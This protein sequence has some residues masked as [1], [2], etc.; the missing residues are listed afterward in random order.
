LIVMKSLLKVLLF[1]VSCVVF[2]GCDRVTKQMAKDHL[3]FSEPISYFHDTFRFEYVENTGAAL[4]VGDA[5]PQKVS[6]WLL[7]IVPLAI[8]IGLF[9]YVI[10]QLNNFSLLKLLSFSLVIAGG[11]GNIIDRIAYDRH[12]TDFMNLGIKDV[13]TGIFN[14]ADVC[15]TV[16]VIGLFIAYFN[17]NKGLMEPDNL[18][19]DP[20]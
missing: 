3:M 17:K 11:L 9:V 7:S 20:A 4:S 12:V 10:S 14:V 6:F 8:L 13:R 18:P 2:I 19:G 15:I 1:C 5:L 16:G